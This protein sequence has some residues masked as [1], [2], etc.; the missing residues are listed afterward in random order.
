MLALE[1]ESVA[2]ARLAAAVAPAALTIARSMP[3][4]RARGVIAAER[5]GGR[6]WLSVCL[7][8]K[9]FEGSRAV[10]PLR[11]PRSPAAPPPRFDVAR[12]RYRGV[13]RNAPYTYSTRA[14]VRR[15]RAGASVTR[16]YRIDDDDD[17]TSLGSSSSTPPH[18]RTH[19][20]RTHATRA[21]R[22]PSLSAASLAGARANRAPHPAPRPRRP[23]GRGD[24]RRGRVASS[25][26]PSSLRLALTTP[27]P[28]RP[29]LAF[30]AM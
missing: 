5:G 14:R 16:A 20:P 26:V 19:A 7:A 27:A 9:L 30:A 6:S 18:A 28:P 17:E 4:S 21:R 25:R 29:S 24:P 23:D 8:R 11:L 13:R 2:T 22:L 1:E 12:R 3:F 10:A 15:R